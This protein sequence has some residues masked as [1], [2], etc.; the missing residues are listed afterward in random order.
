[1]NNYSLFILFFGIF[2]CTLWSVFC[3]IKKL[4]FFDQKRYEINTKIM[5][6]SLR[7][8]LSKHKKFSSQH[9][10]TWLYWSLINYFDSRGYIVS[11]LFLKKIALYN[12]FIIIN[13]YW[14][15][16]DLSL[17]E[18]LNLY[19]VYTYLCMSYISCVIYFK[20]YFQEPKR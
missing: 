1:M 4:I 3:D 7:I 14:G 20:K 12:Y 9:L 8:N 5:Y 17:I 10:R 19:L 6:Y 13:S 2:F 15:L 11:T 16:F 18:G